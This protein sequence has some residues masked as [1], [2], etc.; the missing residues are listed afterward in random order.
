MDYKKMT[1]EEYLKEEKEKYLYNKECES[2]KEKFNKYDDVVK[3]IV[4]RKFAE[5]ETDEP[6]YVYAPDLEKVE[7]EHTKALICAE[8]VQCAID[9]A[10]KSMETVMEVMKDGSEENDT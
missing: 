8:I 4:K 2:F 7:L 5:K 6:C 3:S 1:L 9:T 10:K